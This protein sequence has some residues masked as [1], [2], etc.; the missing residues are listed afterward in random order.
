MS[1]KRAIGRPSKYKPEYCEML[2]EHMKTGLSFETFATVVGAGR[3][4]IYEWARVHPEFS[5]AKTK[6]FEENLAFWEK[7]GISGMLGHIQGFNAAVF[8][9][10]MKNRHHWRDKVDIESKSTVTT[11]KIGFEDERTEAD[12]AEKD[13]ATEKA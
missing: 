10:N 7:A 9:F 8:I 12:I 13:A 1:E 3:E 4:T 5:D 2:I 11:I 6:G